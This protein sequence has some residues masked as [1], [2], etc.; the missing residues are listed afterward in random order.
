MLSREGREGNERELSEERKG[1]V[2]TQRKERVLTEER[3][4][5]VKTEQSRHLP[6]PRPSPNLLQIHPTLIPP[7]A[8]THLKPP[9]QAHTHLRPTPTSSPAHVQS[10]HI[11]EY[12]YY[13][14]IKL[15]VRVTQTRPHTQL[16]D[17]SIEPTII[18]LSNQITCQTMNQLV[19]CLPAEPAFQSDESSSLPGNP[20]V[21]SFNLPVSPALKLILSFHFSF[22]S[23]TLTPLPLPPQAIETSQ[24][25]QCC[26]A[27]PI[28]PPASTSNQPHS[29]TR[30]YRYGS[31][32]SRP[33]QSTSNLHDHFAFCQYR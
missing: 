32:S 26:R 27:S 3:E 13:W 7:Q 9:P 6:Q 2:M 30:L 33:F 31:P 24:S 22:S 23:F 5:R 17:R 19:P 28:P 20:V 29:P 18:Q 15:A 10:T 12:V 16:S 21:Y 25:F 4:G 14:P 11:Y 8:H 1:R